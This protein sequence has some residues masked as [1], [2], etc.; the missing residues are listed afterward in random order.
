METPID[1]TDSATP[2]PNDLKTAIIVNETD[3]KKIKQKIAK[4]KK[5]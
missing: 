2:T 3:I 5:K 4:P 1:A